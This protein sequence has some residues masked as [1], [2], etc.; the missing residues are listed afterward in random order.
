MKDECITAVAKA[1]GRTIS[2]K[3]AQDIEQRISNGLKMLAQK[4]R[5]SFLKMDQETRLREASKVA[6]DQLEAEAL[7]KKQRVARTIQAHDRV[8][9]YLNQ[10]K[11]KFPDMSGV[12]AMMRKLAFHADM[13]NIETSIEYEA[14]A[15]ETDSL[16]Q[17]IS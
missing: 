11:A 3:E 6:G 15:I 4:D 1:I 9:N 10:M 17:M 2:Q 8:E 13:K 5:D 7:K 12:D 14:K 16:R